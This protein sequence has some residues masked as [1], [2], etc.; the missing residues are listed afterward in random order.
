MK[1][2]VIGDNCV[3]AAGTVVRGIIPE[4]SLV[5]NEINVI[6]KIIN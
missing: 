4:N 2:T 3:V 1:G 6:N 5:H